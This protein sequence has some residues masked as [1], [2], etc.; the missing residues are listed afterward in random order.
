MSENRNR[1]TRR[2]VLRSAAAAAAAAGVASPL[3]TACSSGGGQDAAAQ[4][5][6]VKL[7]AHVPNTAVPEPDLPRVHVEG[8]DGYLHY[9]ADASKTVRK[10]PGKGGKVSAFVQTYT[11]APP[12]ASRN[13]YW[14]ELNGRLNADLR[15]NIA[16][17]SDYKTKIATLMAGDDLP[18]FIQILGGGTVPELAPF[19]AAKCQDLTEFL[20]GDEIKNFS[21]LANLPQ[22]CWKSTLYNGGIYGLPI[23]RPRAVLAL[24]SRDDLLEAKGLNPAPQTFDEW[25]EVMKEFNDPA[26]N[27]WAAGNPLTLLT[28]VQMMLGMPNNWDVRQGK[29]V[30]TVEMEETKEAL[31]ALVKIQKAGLLHPDAFV[32]SAPNQQWFNSGTIAFTVDPNNGWMSFFNSNVAGDSFKITGRPAFSFHKGQKPATWLQEPSFWNGFTALKKSDKDRTRELLG[33]ANWLAAP[34]GSQ[35]YLFR[36]YGL[37]GVHHKVDSKGDPIQNERG[38]SEILGMGLQ[39]VTDGPFTFYYPNEPDVVRGMRNFEDGFFKTAVE[40]PVY[41]HYSSALSRKGAQL[42]QLLT[43]SKSEIIQGRKPVSSWDDTVQTWRQRG[44]DQIRDE[45]MKSIET[46]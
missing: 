32:A 17:A 25:F 45:F 28:M 40:N 22:I 29:L 34:F 7:P 27:R 41:G 26:R 20:S 42:D 39:F 43:D 1:P 13:K 38:K 21:N 3:L 24:F 30:S 8:I 31:G 36:K 15:M 5:A 2:T 16:A 33:I 6:A 35:E 10:A 14:R 4:N 44:G 11:P 12:G 18:D 37:E 9:P 23:P 19:L 46:A